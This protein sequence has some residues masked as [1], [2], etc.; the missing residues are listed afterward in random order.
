[1]NQGSGFGWFVG[2]DDATLPFLCSIDLDEYYL[3]PA[4]CVK[5]IREGRS[6]VRELF[7]DDVELPAVSCPHL[8][9]GHVACLGAKVLFPRDSEP[10]VWPIFTDIDSA[11]EAVKRETDFEENELYRHYIGVHE[12]LK[13]EFPDEN[14]KF[15]GFGWEGP[16][17][18][19]VL[20]RGKGFC[21]DIYR[22]PERA[23]MFLELLT[24]SI[25]R[26]E[27]LIRRVNSEPEVNPESTGLVDDFSSLIH[28]DLWGEFV[29][30]YWEEFYSRLTSGR[31]TLHCENLDEKH[32][33]YLG[34]VGISYYDPSVSAR[35]SPSIIK[36]NIGIPFTWRL[37]SFEL[38]NMTEDQVEHWVRRSAQEGATHV[39]MYV[40]RI[41]CQGRNPNK[42]KAF[43]SAAKRVQEERSAGAN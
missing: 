41:T 14:V 12:L 35:L 40:E 38:A 32:L 34:Q 27:R 7:G 39:H 30:P 16:V 28:P 3:R 23:K 20:L 21:A 29:V 10:S 1:M 15:S 11:I 17:T 26:F 43:I 13:R 6:R 8:S 4:S 5:A 25:V 33:R 37:P 2:V 36:R 42:V 22:R 31:R 19:A 24:D 18:S 9:Y